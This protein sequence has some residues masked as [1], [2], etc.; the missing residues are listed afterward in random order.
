MSEYFRLPFVVLFLC[1]SLSVAAVTKPNSDGVITGT[2]KDLHGVGVP[3]AA[4]VVRNVGVLQDKSPLDEL[5]ADRAPMT[6]SAY[7]D[8]EGRFR[9]EHLQPGTYSVQV[10]AEGFSDFTQRRVV[11]EAGRV[12]VLNITLEAVLEIPFERLELN[13]IDRQLAS[14]GG[15]KAI[16]LREVFTDSESWQA[17]WAKYN[18][19]APSVDFQKHQVAAIFLG[20]L[21]NLGS[22]K[23]SRITYNYRRKKAVIH[24]ESNVCSGDP[25]STVISG[26]AEIVVFPLK[27]GTTEFK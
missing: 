9:A 17:F 5:F 2:V 11:V 15:F 8:G 13:G 25:C 12:T 24:V 20:T 18:I 16:R 1:T 26:P 14:C 27:P 19:K 7:T 3:S 23:I 22:V 6:G 21:S 10:N 4:V